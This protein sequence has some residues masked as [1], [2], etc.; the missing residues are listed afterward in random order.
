M[1]D[2]AEYGAIEQAT[3]DYYEGWYQADAERM[4]RAIHPALAKRA[5]G[6]GGS[7]DAIDVTTAA[8]MIELT[9]AGRGTVHAGSLVATRISVDH[10]IGAM[11]SVSAASGPYEEFLHLARTSDGWRIVNVLWR[12]ADGHGPRP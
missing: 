6:V 4:A 2:A 9:C 5:F 8:E 7:A 3:L 1:I 10:V 11:A 12:F